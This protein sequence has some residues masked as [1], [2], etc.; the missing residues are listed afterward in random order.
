VARA[1]G[2]RRIFAID[3]CD[4]PLEI[5]AKLGIEYRYR[6]DRDDIVGEIQ[7]LTEGLGVDVIWDTAGT[8]ETFATA[9]ALLAPRGRVINLATHKTECRLD[10]TTLG[11][12][13]YARS[14]ANYRYEEFPVAIDLMATGAVD[15]DPIITKRIPLH[16]ISACMQDLVDKQASGEC[17]VVVE[18]GKGRNEP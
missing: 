1:W 11:A 17:K 10:P 6:A 9:V 15:M 13:R 5:A 18:V 16:E 4:L 7:E 14:S 2:A 8:A 3:I 12:E